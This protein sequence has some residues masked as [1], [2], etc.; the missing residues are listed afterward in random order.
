MKIVCCSNF[1]LEDFEESF[2]ELP[3]RLSD[4]AVKTIRNVIIGELATDTNPVFW[5]IVKDDYVLQKGFEP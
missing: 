3:D 1:G 2:V 5:K 4:E